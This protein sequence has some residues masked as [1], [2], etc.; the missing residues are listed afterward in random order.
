MPSLIRET[1][2]QIY[3]QL[4]N[5]VCLGGD[6]HTDRKIWGENFLSTESTLM[7]DFN[8]IPVEIKTSCIL[9]PFC[10]RTFLLAI[11]GHLSPTLDLTHWYS[12]VDCLIPLN[13]F[14]NF[15][16]IL[17][18]SS[19]PIGLSELVVKSSS[20]SPRVFFPFELLHWIIRADSLI[21]SNQSKNFFTF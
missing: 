12:Q 16:K 1:L 19:N 8:S 3:R 6:Q 15:L 11:S 4:V 20:I 13:L 5:K 18:S 10:I 9:R 14:E 21:F 7:V 17:L 2:W